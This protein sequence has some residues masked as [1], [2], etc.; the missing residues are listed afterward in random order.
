MANEHKIRKGCKDIWNSKMIDDATMLKDM[1]TTHSS[2][3]IPKK[4]ISY[5]DAL[6]I[7]KQNQS[8]GNKKYRIDAFIHFYIDDYKFDNDNGVWQKFPEFLKLLDHFSGCIIPDF[9]TYDDF[10]EPII[11]YNYYRMFAIANAL[12]KN[13]K[14]FIHNLRW[15]Y[16]AMDYCFAGIE[17]GSMVSI[18]VVASKLNNPCIRK[19]FEIG[20]TEA[21]KQIEP[22]TIIIYGSSN[23]SIF[24]VLRSGGYRIVSFKS[25]KNIIFGGKNE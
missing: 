15:N 22:S 1:P 11:K 17:K 9:S 7:D 13:N 14:C 21:I 20:L 24:D 4:L 5:T 18:G 25:K 2:N 19:C 3:I 16:K 10:P 23:Y 12:K 6:A 8:I